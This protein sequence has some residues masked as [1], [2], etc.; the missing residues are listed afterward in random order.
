MAFLKN[1]QR[2]IEAKTDEIKSRNTQETV[3]SS[4]DMDEAYYDFEDRY[5]TTCDRKEEKIYN[6]ETDNRDP[7]K[8]VKGFQKML[9]LCHDLEE[10]CTSKGSG[11]AAYFKE[12]YSHIYREI[13]KDLDDYM[14][15]DYAEAKEYFEEEKAKQKA[16]K[17]LANKIFKE[18]EKA[19]GSAMQKDLR[20]QFPK[21]EP[22]YFNQAVKS[23]LE[24]GKIDKFKDGSHVVYKIS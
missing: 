21:G 5:G 19:D 14:K 23:L 2:K 24:S 9:E 6:V 15:N 16:I 8:N 12:N 7:D 22:D 18:I 17:S 3:K 1:L 4:F 13:Q 10:F 11:G 20:K